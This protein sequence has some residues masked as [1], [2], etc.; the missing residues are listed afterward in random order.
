MAVVS[1]YPK[2]SADWLRHEKDARL[3]R[4]QVTILAATGNLATGA[5]LGQIL[6]GAATSAAK[7]G[8]NTGGGSLTLDATTPKLVGVKAG[9]YKV[10]AIGLAANGGI[11]SVH[12]PDEIYI[13]NYTI[14][15]PDFA[16]QIKFAMA[17][18][19]TDFAVG[20]GFDITVA[21]GSGKWAYYDPTAVNGCAVP[22]GILLDARDVSGG[23]DVAG[24]VVTGEAEIVAIGLAWGAAVDDADKKSAGVALLAKLGFQTRQ[25]S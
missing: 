22:R 13:G 15:G 17:D 23:A 24:V 21:A 16:N 12:D 4:K 9:V 14:G 11:F 7:A 2:L 3:H 8:G 19:G 10:R 1:N 20:D 25:L 18:S 5:V 6:A